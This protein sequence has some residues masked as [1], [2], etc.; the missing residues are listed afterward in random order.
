[1][2]IQHT[3]SVSVQAGGIKPAISQTTLTKHNGNEG[4][5]T[6]NPRSKFAGKNLYEALETVDS[7]ATGLA[8]STG[9]LTVADSGPELIPS[10]SAPVWK[11]YGNKL[12]VF[13]TH[14]RLFKLDIG[15]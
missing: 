14:E 1:M 9:T 2:L 4:H 3:E 12:R 8:S 7:E 11:I 15:R 5:S 6:M 13:G 10:F